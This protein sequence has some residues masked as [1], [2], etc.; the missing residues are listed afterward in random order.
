MKSEISTTPQSQDWLDLAGLLPSLPLSLSQKLFQSTGGSSTSD[1]TFE[2]NL[3]TR[4]YYSSHLSSQIQSQV[5]NEL[6]KFIEDRVQETFRIRDFL[7]QHLTKIESIVGKGNFSA[8]WLDREAFSSDSM[9]HRAV[10]TEAV[11]HCYSASSLQKIVEFLYENRIPMIPYG[12]GGGYNMGVTPMAPAVTISVR[13]IDHIHSIVPHPTKPNQHQITVGAGVPFKDLIAYLHKKGFVLRCDPNTPRA[14]VGGIAAT[15][16]NGGRKAFEVIS[17]GRAVLPNGKAVKFEADA[18]EQALIKS[19]PFL[20]SK[21]FFG[22]ARPAFFESQYKNK[23]TQSNA[24]ACPSPTQAETPVTLSGVKGRAQMMA[25]A[26]AE[27]RSDSM[28]QTPT[29]PLSVFV[30]AEGTTGFIFEVTFDIEKPKPLVMGM[31]WH[32]S[33]TEAAMLVT[34]AIKSL[35]SLDQPVYFELLTSPS[36]QRYLIEDYPST[37]HAQD[38][39]VLIMGIEG[40][41]SASLQAGSQDLLQLA[42]Q[43]LKENSV[44]ESTMHHTFQTVA[45]PIQKSPQFDLLKKPREMLPKKL[46]TKVKTDMEVRFEYLPQVLEIVKNTQ[47]KELANQKVDVLFGHLTP[48]HTSILHWNIG[49]FDVYSEH[50]AQVAWDYLESVIQNA[51]SLA[52]KEDPWGSARF[53]GEHGMAGKAPFLWINYLD[54]DE[55]Q[56]MLAVKNFLDPFDL[57]NPNTLFL[58]TSLAKKLRARLISS[59]DLLLRTPAP[60]TILGPVGAERSARD[61]AIQEALK[62]TRCNS[63]KICPVIDA[64]HELEKK[65][66]RKSTQ[67][68]LPS[69]RNLLLFMERMA[70]IRSGAQSG[71]QPSHYNQVMEVTQSMFAESA[72]LLKKCFYCRRCDKAC[73][74]DIKI[75]PLMQAFQSMAGTSIKSPLPLRFLYERLMGTDKWKSFNYFLFAFLMI[76]SKPFLSLIRRTRFIPQWAKTYFVTPSVSLRHYQPLKAGSKTSETDNFVAIGRGPELVGHS[77]LD[78]FRVYIRFRGCVDTFSHPGATEAVDTYF[79]DELGIK[80]LDLEKKICC[81][82]PF[83][84]DG[85]KT[86]AQELRFL[87]LSEI[88]KTIVRAREWIGRQKESRPLQMIVFSNCPTCCEAIKEMGESLKDP[89]IVKQLY[90]NGSVP[91]GTH[92]QELEFD[93]QDTAQIAVNI[94]EKA[95]LVPGALPLKL[96]LGKSDSTVGIKVPCHNTPAA[97][98]AQ[99]KLLDYYF[100]TVQNYEKC[101]GLSGTGRIKNP[102][103]GTQIA[104]TLFESIEASPAPAVLSGCPSCRDG[105]T[106]Q[107]EIYVSEGRSEF[108]FKVEGIFEW[109]LKNPKKSLS[110]DALKG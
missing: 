73:P 57:C 82:F 104:Q 10:I 94:L 23:L 17:R 98:L 92:P 37:F 67:S 19:E 8:L 30:G 88:C 15:G 60:P 50:Q 26:S 64:E 53:S 32:F 21:K 110:A 13:G 46:R 51:Q 1:H 72:R 100:K 40:E 56:R 108:D 42:F 78:P 4:S 71:N 28:A 25:K 99:Q 106:L 9:E 52:P 43:I 96:G 84:A 48:H 63:C 83:E 12:E 103:I 14:A 81:G 76:L 77:V 68:V 62:C 91:R 5:P 45:E 22:V 18:E 55:Y 69:K 101:C 47:P 35:P 20:M 3:I 93:V 65:Q 97:T 87:A 33:D 11:I 29:L 58:R 41:T 89:H 36:I 109:I 54:P 34:K 75:N 70:L 105:V 95:K 7:K 2:P 24:T 79:K 61:Y 80:F 59:T 31:R 49:G 6:F 16:S 27:L 39:A 66:A 86:R 102:R 74:V 90:N 38:A 107:K 44:L 85:L